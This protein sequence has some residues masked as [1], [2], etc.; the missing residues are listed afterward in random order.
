MDTIVCK[1]GGTSTADSNC[2]IQIKGI[3]EADPR[4]RY[5]VLSAPGG[6]P[7]VTEL[8]SRLW[9]AK[10]CPGGAE[11]ILR[12][13][14]RR[15][16]DIALPLGLPDPTP[17]VK[18]SIREALGISQSHTLSRGEALCARLFSEYA[19]L[20][21][22]DAAQVIRF[23]HTGHLDE[24]ATHA[25]VK[26]MAAAVPRAVIPG[27]YGADPE[28]RVKLLPRNGSD[29]TGALVAAGAGAVLYENWTDVPG[30]MTDDPALCPDVQVIPEISYA[31]MRRRA[32]NG[33][34]VLHPDC[35]KPVARAG[36]P[37]RI[38]RTRDPEAPGTRVR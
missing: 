13:I 12:A 2:F 21:M 5:I 34:R 29:I 22:I 10:N 27:F 20:P 19:R 4:R 11:I 24:S 3:L 14:A 26:D 25:A 18:A 8:L 28:G 1:F 35:L 17:W 31:D 32:L 15:F 33:A 38:C 16:S 6:N 23:D 36:I 9:E 30:L 7:K 37:T